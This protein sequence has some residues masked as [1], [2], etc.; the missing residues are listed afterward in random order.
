MAMRTVHKLVTFN[1]EFTIRGLDGAHPPGTYDTVT[2]EE[3][4]DG[5]TFTGWHRVNTSFRLPAVGVETGQ[6][7]YTAIS[8]ND[9]QIALKN[10]RAV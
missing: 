6:L 5:L 4:I 7:Q 3:R 1:R 10:D 9:L 2:L 8:P